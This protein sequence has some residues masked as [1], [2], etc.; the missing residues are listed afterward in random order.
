MLATDNVAVGDL[1]HTGRICVAFG[2]SGDGGP[3]TEMFD[4][5]LGSL[6]AQVNDF[7]DRKRE[8]G[9]SWVGNPIKW[10]K[11]HRK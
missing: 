8:E 4:D 6:Q 9:F 5:E 11:I 7:I 3:V 1:P 2:Y 10:V